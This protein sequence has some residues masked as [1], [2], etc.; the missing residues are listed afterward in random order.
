MKFYLAMTTIPSRLNNPDFLRRVLHL[1]NQTRPFEKLFITIPIRYKRFQDQA[2][3]SIIKVL[4]SIEFVEIISLDVDYGPACKFLGPMIKKRREI[5]S[6]ILIVM[7]DDR[8][9]D[10]SMI[11]VYHDFFSD[12]PIDL[13][14]SGNQELYFRS[15]RF[16]NLKK[17][18]YKI[19]V[20]N[21]RYVSGFMSFALRFKDELFFDLIDY[22]VRMIQDVKDVFFHDEGILLN[23]LTFNKITVHYINY[24]FVDVIDREM[25][26][27]LCLLPHINRIEVE[28]NIRLYTNQ[29]KYFSEKMP[30]FSRKTS[31]MRLKNIL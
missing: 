5:E 16:A 27:A 28:N 3:D 26:D 6:N 25:E 19:V 22:S 23:F 11:E 17:D 15:I 24:P 29:I 21:H 1:K 10:P 12:H 9:Y 13:V 4:K 14:A 20:A 31:I 8:F 7:D 30:A 18:D 2:K